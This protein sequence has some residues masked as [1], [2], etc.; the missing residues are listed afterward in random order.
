MTLSNIEIEAKKQL[1]KEAYDYIARGSGDEVTMDANRNAFNKWTIRPRVLRD[2]NE[3]NLET[4]LFGQTLKAPVLLAPIGVQ[5][6]AHPEGELAT[7]RAAASIG[8]P[9][10]VSSASSYSMEEIAKEM[11]NHTR[12]FQLY[13]STEDSVTE[14]LVRRAEANGYS[15]IV[16]T[17]DTPM[18]G[19]RKTDYLNNYSP[20]SEGHGCGNY[21]TDPAFCALLAKSPIEDKAAA[22]QK[23][24]D[25]I[26]QPSLNWDDLK[27]IRTYTT[28]PIV[29]KGI[30]HP[31]D[32]QLALDYG[33]DG[34]IVSNHGGRQLDHCIA[35]LDAL[36]DIQKIIQGRIP[37][38][39]DS[40]IRNGTDIIK[41]LALGANAVLLGRPYIY[42]LATGGQAG[43][44][45]VITD[46]LHEL[47]VS[48]ALTGMRS[49]GEIDDSILARN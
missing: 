49:I 24:I 4:S 47:D 46:L 17:V 28:L 8:I 39:I 5:R 19:V 30:L 9:Y 38:L 12:W 45:Q 43:T 10:I 14:S 27:K 37:V 29:L 31:D 1:T 22:L 2:V 21:L 42:G 6:I 41:A 35:S 18:L 33:V 25:I 26:D 44:E 20:L 34:I 36:Q 16:I 13:C 7:A 32:A 40:G 23:Q 11:G 15:A 48:M 3:R